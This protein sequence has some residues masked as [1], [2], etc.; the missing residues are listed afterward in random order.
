M[1]T[2][3]KTQV[4]LIGTVVTE[5]TGTKLPSVRMALGLLLNKHIDLK[6]TTRESSTESVTEISEFWYKA[7][8]PIQEKKNCLTKLE[9]IFETWRGLKKNKKRQTETQRM[10]ETAFAREL[11]NVFDIAHANA[12][13][14]I[15][16]PEDR[17]FLLAQREPGRRGS[18][19]GVDMT[20]AAKEKRAAERGEILLAR[21]R[22]A[23]EYEESGM[24]TAELV[25]SDGSSDEK[26]VPSVDDEHGVVGAC[27]TPKTQKRGRSIVVTPQLSAAL[28]RTKVSD[29]KATFIIAETAKSLGHNIDNIA[30]NP[31]SIRRQRMKHRANEAVRLKKEFIE[32]HHL[33]SLVVHWDGKLLPNLTGKA[34]VDR[35][36]VLVS[37]RGVAQLLAVAKLPTGSG[38]AQ[39][40]AVYEALKDWDIADKVRAMCF[41]TTSSNTGRSIGA[42]VLLEQKLGRELLSLAC[43]H[44]LMELII[45]SV[46]NV[47][48]GC[49]SAPEVLV[50]K[51]F[52]A[53][54]EFID[55]SLY[56]TGVD[57]NDVSTMVQDVRQNILDFANEQVKCFITL[58]I[59]NLITVTQPAGMYS[60][61][62]IISV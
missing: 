3:S 39:A 44:H 59:E 6:L 54:W 14:M 40:S 11:D 35:L 26:D 61:F 52:Q 33:V 38:A 10:W 1:A 43:R 7:R 28:D 19:A 29:R 25:S 46:F 37:G 45:G 5:L 4:F 17:D 60:S 20:L 62:I 27:V 32:G 18:M 41:D 9:K 15:T 2:R 21:R 12:L 47:C 22:R 16:V 53:Y 58:Q 24:A 36:P 56:G 13:N 50:F 31:A 48:L 23:V 30:I 55:K 57:N 49:T 42:C 51:R 8:I 34:N